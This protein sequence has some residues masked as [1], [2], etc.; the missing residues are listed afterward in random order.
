[1][2]LPR[3]ISPGIGALALALL[4]IAPAIH[5][6]ALGADETLPNLADNIDRP[7]RYRPEGADFVI[8]TGCD[9]A[10][11]RQAVRRILACLGKPADS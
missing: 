3:C 5:G 10:E 7:L 9:P 6:Q 11:T 2:I 4:A 1:M 8:E